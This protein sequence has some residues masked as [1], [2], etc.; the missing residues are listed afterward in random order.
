VRFRRVRRR[1]H[2]MMG[3]VF[4]AKRVESQLPCGCE[5]GPIRVHPVAAHP[6]IKILQIGNYPPPFCGWALQTKLLVEEI[7][8]RGHVCEV[9][10]L[11]ENRRKKSSEYVD[12]QNAFDYLRKVI[13][14][15]L[16]GYRFQVHVNGQSKP[17]YLLALVAALVGR[18][19]RKPVALNWHGGLRQRFFPRLADRGPR[20]AFRLLF[21]LAGRILCNSTAVKRAIVDYGIDP[22]QVVAIPGFSSQHLS[23]TKVPLSEATE[24]FLEFHRPVF[25]CYLSFRPEYKLPVLREAM[26][27]FRERYT[28]SGFI[29]LGFPAKESPAAKAYVDSWP[30]QER[31][32]LLLLGN[33]PHDEFLTLLGRS[34]A[35]VRTPACDG[36]SASI[37]ECLALGVPVL[38]SQN[39]HRPA[40][41]MTYREGD[42][43]D[44]CAKL[45]AIAESHSPIRQEAP[46]QEAEDNIAKTADWLLED[47]RELRQEPEQ[48]LIHVQ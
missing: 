7:R 10:N 35:Y 18:I 25:F 48:S 42:A 31:G 15:A 37:L 1:Q 38:A 6:P 36:V 24:Q 21:R 23:F 8:N 44:L 13:R 20:L 45:I 43:R 22:A 30:A 5:V 2:K 41:V 34:S 40:G 19:A 46:F 3:T 4:N 33:L 28:E 39:G 12:V 17:G 32:G 9:L 26:S 47:P 14:F 27:Q 11:N 16:K 29:W